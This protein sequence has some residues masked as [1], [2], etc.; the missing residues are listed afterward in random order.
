[1]RS[2]IRSVVRITVPHQYCRASSSSGYPKLPGRGPASW[3][4][5]GASPQF[6][7]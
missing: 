3:S 7:A 5:F 4:P 2:R 1:M 6:T